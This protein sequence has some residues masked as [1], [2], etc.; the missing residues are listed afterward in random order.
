MAWTKAIG[1]GCVLWG[2]VIVSLLG[3]C[4][5]EITGADAL[6]VEAKSVVVDPEQ[7]GRSRFGALTLLSSFAL[8]ADDK[9]FGGL[10]GVALDASGHI[11]YAVSD[12]GY[13]LSAR[14]AWPWLIIE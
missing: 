6:W 11:L 13:G 5:A 10:S 2:V 14:P 1:A 7:P 9:R 8:R 3:G 4:L 12:R